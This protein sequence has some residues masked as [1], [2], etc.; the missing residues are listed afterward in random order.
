MSEVMLM[1]VQPQGA[2]APRADEELI[3]PEIFPVASLPRPREPSKYEI[4]KHNL[5]PGPC[6]DVV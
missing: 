2:H 3:E 1:D 6:Y 4:E 5:L